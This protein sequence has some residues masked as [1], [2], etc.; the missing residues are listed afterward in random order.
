[1]VVN[2]CSQRPGFFL[3]SWS[4]AREKGKTQE[5]WKTFGSFGGGGADGSFLPP[6]LFLYFYNPLHERPT[7]HG[8]NSQWERSKTPVQSQEGSI[9]KRLQIWGSRAECSSGLMKQK[10]YQTNYWTCLG[11]TDKM[12]SW[13]KA[14]TRVA[15][16]KAKVLGP[17][18]FS[19]AAGQMDFLLLRI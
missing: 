9:L 5:P 2:H 10:D 8:L 15:R 19:I 7:D 16:N 12:K 4:G 1:M 6:I 14:G 3:C 18:G 13:H 11:E 17:T